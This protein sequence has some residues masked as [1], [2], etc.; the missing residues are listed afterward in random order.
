MNTFV[1]S[2][3]NAPAERPAQLDDVTKI[4]VAVSWDASGALTGGVRGKAAER[5]GTDLDEF[6]VLRS[7]GDPKRLCT[8]VSK[9][10][11]RP[12]DDEAPG[13]ILHTG[14]EKTGNAS[15][16][17][18]TIEVDLTKIPVRYDDIVFAVAAFKKRNVLQRLS[19]DL[20]GFAAASNVR[21]TGI[22][23]SG[24]QRVEEWHI[25]PSLLGTA[26]CCL[27]ARVSRSHPADTS[28]PW[29]IAILEQFVP[30]TPGDPQ[31]LLRAAA[32][33]PHL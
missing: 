26:N 4:A 30:I 23:L 20:E 18:E 15:G 22:N 28:A 25:E 27:V 12:L 1:L 5:I 8:G 21:F 24:G 11:M 9:K 19:S 7:K 32:S 17:D 16:Y 3:D 13:A 14:D 29:R 10:F 6:A 33:V 31:S 2:K